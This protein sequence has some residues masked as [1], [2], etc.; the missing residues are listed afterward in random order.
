MLEVPIQ[1]ATDTQLIL[2]VDDIQDNLD[3]MAEFLDDGNWSI[4]CASSGEAALDVLNTADVSLVLLDVQMNGMDG[5][6]VARRMRDNPRTRVIPII[7]LSGLPQ[8]HE[9]LSKGYAQG[10]VD[11]IKKPCDPV[12]LRHKVESLLEHGRHR[13]ELLRL[14]QQLEVERAF[15]AS[16][17]ASAAEGIMVVELDG[18]IRFANP[19]MATLLK[20]SL[21]SLQGSAL[22]SHVLESGRPTD[23]Q[24]SF[25]FNLWQGNQSFRLSDV[26][27]RCQSGETVPVKLSCSALPGDSQ[28]LVLMVLDMSV[29]RHLHAQLESLT[30]TDALTGL[31]NR[32]GFYHAME[33]ALAR[34]ERHANSMAVLFLDLDGFKRINDSLGHDAGD[35]LLR[36]VSEYLQ[37]CLRPYDTLARLGGDEFTVLLDSLSAPEDAGR[38]AQKLIDVVSTQ[39]SIAGVDFSLGVSIGIACLPECGQTV[40][41]VLRAADVAMYEAKRGGR[42]QFRFFSREMQAQES[43]RQEI[44]LQLEQA[45]TGNE[46][47]L[48]YQPQ[49]D[50][51]SGRVS[52]FEA[53]LRWPQARAGTFLAGEFI[54]MLESRRLINRL[55]DWITEE[56]VSQCAQLHLHREP[57]AHLCMNIGALQFSRLQLADELGQTLAK[58][59]VKPCQVTLEISEAVLA[60]SLKHNQEQLGRLRT[61]GVRIA[62]D[63]FGRGGLSLESISE[64][65]PDVLKL[66][67]Q[68]LASMFDSPRHT[69]LLHSMIELGRNLGLEVVAV[70]VETPKQYDWLKA[71]GCDKAQGYL[72][73]AALPRTEAFEFAAPASG[74]AL[75]AALHG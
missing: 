22:V 39:Q 6:E 25:I 12:V 19:T 66:D 37:G 36:R 30:I 55:H 38:V 1:R 69:K 68:L 18:T 23:W 8:S 56:L 17:L 61:L 13:R 3:G 15:N 11:F 62:V 48:F 29:E 41:E 44:E 49:I 27:L 7:F 60:Q 73:A 67:R 32:R 53:L 46:F 51:H 71:N 50:L 40:D 10:A 16:I 24:Q 65:E 47:E 43:A 42:R 74:T 4:T 34:T 57:A 63:N 72:I 70:G 28:A 64:M 9:V 75:R 31:L 14:S 54:A 45:V 21:A 35:V 2:V 58:H 33:S 26:V 5:F 59:S 52:A 20:T